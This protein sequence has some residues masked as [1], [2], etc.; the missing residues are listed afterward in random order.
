MR[1]SDGTL[2]LDL[3]PA[4]AALVQ[5]HTQATRDLSAQME[6]MRQQMQQWAELQVRESFPCVAHGVQGG[7]YYWLATCLRLAI[8]LCHVSA[9]CPVSEDHAMPVPASCTGCAAS[10]TIVPTIDIIALG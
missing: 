8:L 6:A 5:E 7:Q 1:D 3:A 10:R 9:C 2:E 4:A